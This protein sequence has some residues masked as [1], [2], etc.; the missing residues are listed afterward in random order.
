MIPEGV[1]N[2]S[3]VNTIMEKSVFVIL[4]VSLIPDRI[5][6]D[7]NLNIEAL[8]HFITIY[9]WLMLVGHEIPGPREIMCDSADV[10]SP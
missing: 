10:I 9:I 1:V 7:E 3:D 2:R 8:H 5:G 6:C 4:L